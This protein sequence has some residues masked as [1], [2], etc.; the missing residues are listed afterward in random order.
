MNLIHDAW[1]PVRR[2]NGEIVRIAPW[3]VTEGNGEEYVELAAP[4]P[5]FNGA[6]IQFLIGLLQTACPPKNAGVWREW[7]KNPP[8]PDVLKKAFESVAKVFELGGDGPHFHAGS[9]AQDQEFGKKRDRRSFNR[10]AGG[11]R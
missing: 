5:D 2:K 1:I 10:N 4:R 7:L 3:Q 9:D 11:M 8:K 6:L